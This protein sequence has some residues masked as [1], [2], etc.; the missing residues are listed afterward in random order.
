[1]LKNKT[2]IL[3][4]ALELA[5]QKKTYGEIRKFVVSNTSD[6]ENVKRIMQAVDDVILNKT[7][8]K[9]N[10]KFKKIIFF[11]VVLLLFVP[12]LIY[13]LQGKGIIV[14]FPTGSILGYF[15]FNNFRNLETIKRNSNTR[16]FKSRF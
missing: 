1:M 13:F 8:S 7:V 16:R 14:F 3:N 10:I 11:L 12:S 4:T 9:K 5:E 2:D 6:K 15:I